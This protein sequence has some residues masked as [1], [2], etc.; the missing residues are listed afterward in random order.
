MR[1]AHVVATNELA[2]PD[3]WQQ[4]LHSTYDGMSEHIIAAL[5]QI[6]GAVILVLLG[7]LIAHLLRLLT[8]RFITSFINLLSKFSSRRLSSSAQIAVY[9]KI[10]GN[11]VFWTVLLFFIAAALRTLA[12]QWFS[13]LVD[14]IVRYLPSL[15]AGLAIIFTGAVLAG[16]VRS[17]ASNAAI[18]LHI[19]PHHLVGRVAQFT[20]LVTALMVGIEHIGINLSFLSMTF[21]VILGASLLGASLAFGLGAKDLLANVIG[22]QN[23]RKHLNIGYVIKLGHTEGEIVDITSTNLIIETERGRVLVPARV[24]HEQIIE[25]IEAAPSPIDSSAAETQP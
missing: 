20:V 4:A 2:T 15:L 19:E 23:S 12:F 6:A 1:N 5:P 24:C 14:V 16:L 9:T 21:I 11:I 22:A 8:R 3:N 10:G 7:L 17:I 18:S 25:I 13:G